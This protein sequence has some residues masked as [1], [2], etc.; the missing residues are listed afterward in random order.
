MQ[1][2]APRCWICR[3]RREPLRENRFV[4]SVACDLHLANVHLSC[5]TPSR[6]APLQTNDACATAA[7]LN[8]DEHADVNMDPLALMGMA[9]WDMGTQGT[10]VRTD[11]KDGN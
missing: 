3:R 9:T 7:L 8:F 11:G 6:C 10:Q 4:R 1:P 2:S 5:H